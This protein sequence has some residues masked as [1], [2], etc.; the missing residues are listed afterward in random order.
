MIIPFFNQ[1]NMKSTIVIKAEISYVVFNPKLEIKNHK[2]KLEGKVFNITSM[3][4]P[5]DCWDFSFNN[6]ELCLATKKLKEI[7]STPNDYLM[8]KR[9]I[10]ERLFNSYG[11]DE[12]ELYDKIENMLFYWKPFSYIDEGFPSQI[13]GN[14]NTERDCINKMIEC[15]ETLCNITNGYKIV[16]GKN[17]EYASGLIATTKPDIKKITELLN[18]IKNDVL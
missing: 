14:F 3:K 16:K 2:L 11:Y 13:Y 15:W 8:K 6:A 12:T 9:E 7:M 4:T 5:F 17:T 1:K 18:K 10:L